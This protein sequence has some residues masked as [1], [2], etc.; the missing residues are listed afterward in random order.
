MNDAELRSS[1]LAAAVNC[2]K[3][4]YPGHAPVAERSESSPTQTFHRR[5]SLTLAWSSLTGSSSSPSE[6]STL[7]C[8]RL[9]NPVKKMATD[10]RRRSPSLKTGAHKETLIRPSVKRRGSVLG[11]SLQ[12]FVSRTPSPE[13][14]APFTTGK[15]RRKSREETNEE[16]TRSS[17]EG[18]RAVALYDYIAE[19]ET[20][21]PPDTRRKLTMAE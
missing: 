7:P 11:R 20:P 21:F 8:A 9:V 16:Q 3:D 19:E 5:S 4:E 12:T 6:T 18:E 13:P 10:V 2:Q 17:Y 14:G 15:S 1:V